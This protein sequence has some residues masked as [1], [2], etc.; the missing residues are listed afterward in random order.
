VTPELHDD[1]LLIRPAQTGD[2]RALSALAKRTWSA[3][4]GSSLSPDDEV[5]ELEET[6]S[7]AY[8]SNALPEKTIL[9]AEANGALLGY[10]QFGDVEI[11]EVDARPGDQ[12]LQRLY[13]ETALQ[14]CGLGRR[15]MNAALQHPRLAEARRIFLQ[16]WDEN[17]RAV[18][19]YESLGFQKVGT[20]TFTIGSEVMEDLVMVLDRGEQARAGERPVAERRMHADEVDTDVDLIRRLLAAQ[21]PQWADLAIEPVLP[22]GT[23]NA[24]YRLGSDMVARLPRMERPSATLAKERRWLPRLAPLL[25]LAVPVPLAVGKPGEGYPFD[26]SI[27]RWLEG[28]TAADAAIDD[29]RQ[30]ATELAEFIAALQRVDATDGPPPGEHNFFRGVALARRDAATRAAIDSLGREIEADA[31]TAAWETALSAPEWEG[32]P[33]WIHGDLDARNLLVENGRLSAVIDFGGLGVGDPAC[34]VMVAWKVLSADARDVLRAALAVDEATWARARGWAISQALI[35]LAYTAWRRTPR[36]SARRSAGWPR[37]WP[38][39]RRR[40]PVLCMSPGDI[41]AIGDTAR[42]QTRT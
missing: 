26:W 17:E 6:R 4:F 28:E 34:D 5:V 25:P 22:M 33:V 8:F 2:V 3:E 15:L 14:G 40:G 31:V 42:A 11:P 29:L 35:A 16:V 38:I 32:A 21:F 36:S 12:G 13:V 7:E 18:R 9:V 27:Y 20:T 37:R 19:L 23:D 1:A 30:L 41:G 24:L 10:V 39:P